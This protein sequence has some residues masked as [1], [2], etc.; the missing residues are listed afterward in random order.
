MQ[1][2]SVV[3]L[4]FF[5]AFLLLY[6][7]VRGHRGARNWLVVVGSYTFY[8]WWDYRFLA[9][10]LASSLLDYAVGLRLEAT[11]AAPARRR[12]VMVSLAGNLGIL[13]VFKYCG[14][15]V[16]SLAEV[17]TA[18]GF[19]ADLPTLHLV[20]PVG[21]S[22]YTFQTLSYTLDVYR[23]QIV[24]TRDLGAFLAYVSFF[25]QLV[26][27]PIE[28]ASALLPQ[29]TQ[30]RVITRSHLEEGGWL[31]LWGLF[32]KVVVADNLAPLVEM[33]FDHP[34]P[35][36][37][38]VVLG[39]VAFGFQ[40]YADFSGYSDLARG[41]A[42]LLGFELRWNFRLPYGAGNVREFWRRWH[43]SLST[44]LRDYLYISLGGNRRGPARTRLNLVVTMVLGGLWHGAA[45]HFV[46]WGLWHGLGL[47]GHRL[48]ESARSG[49]TARAV[50]EGHDAGGKP[51]APWRWWGWL[52][53]VAFVFYGW[54]LFRAPSLGHAWVMTKALGDWSLP[55]WL[56]SYGFSLV[57]FTAPLVAMQVWQ[58]RREDLLV[59]LTL[60]GWAKALL[61][62]ALLAGV[63]LFWEKGGTPFIYFQF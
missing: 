56:G 24:A 58:A 9:L 31:V 29:F 6:H 22:F 15:F 26:A 46:V 20:L 49:R 5:A 36:G 40:I 8:G 42:R 27:G 13:G 14:F 63:L 33:A 32:K 51:A 37:P 3:F 19:R 7:L 47:L 54:L 41:L 21:I 1:F 44:W 30:P 34:T 25:P 48:W 38:L 53:T 17:L 57:A 59:A 10:L 4:K 2:N 61:Q 62:G 39:T 43:I 50:P 28:R 60:P 35:S 12:W 18:L 55:V 11:S 52:L 16:D 23:R 45:W